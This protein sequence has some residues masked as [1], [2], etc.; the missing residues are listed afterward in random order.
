MGEEV[1]FDEVTK[2]KK[3]VKFVYKSVHLLIFDSRC[4]AKVKIL[5][6]HNFDVF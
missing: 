3:E 2:I 4:V 1:D 6:P 5:N